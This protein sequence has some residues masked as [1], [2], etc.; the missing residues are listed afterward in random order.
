MNPSRNDQRQQVE[1]DNEKVRKRP[2][3][4]PTV[5]VLDESEVLAT[6]QITSAFASWWF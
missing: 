5:K 1:A 2:Y 4:R 6:F 3:R